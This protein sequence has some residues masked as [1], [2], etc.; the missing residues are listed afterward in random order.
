[1]LMFVN[2]ASIGRLAPQ[3]HEIIIDEGVRRVADQCLF[4]VSAV[5]GCTRWTS[6]NVSGLYRK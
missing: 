4:V 3:G 5:N 6:A 2:I 1:M